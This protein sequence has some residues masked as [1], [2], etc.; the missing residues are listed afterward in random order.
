MIDENDVKTQI[1]FS[2]NMTKKTIKLKAI[3]TK[4]KTVTNFD[5]NHKQICAKNKFMMNNK[6]Y[7]K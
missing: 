2:M 4:S 6:V 5:N 1:K 3:T 7:N